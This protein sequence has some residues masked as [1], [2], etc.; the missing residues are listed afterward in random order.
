[1]VKEYK[2]GFIKGFTA[3]LTLMRKAGVTNYEEFAKA[4]LK[5]VPDLPL[6]FEVFS[7]DSVDMERQRG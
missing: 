7:D 2:K 5:V 6:S 4:A 1:M 3:N